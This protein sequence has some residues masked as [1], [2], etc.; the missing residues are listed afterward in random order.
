MHSASCIPI[1]HTKQKQE[2]VHDG[3]EGGGMVS[4]LQHGGI[5]SPGA[6]LTARKGYA[7]P[8]SLAHIYQVLVAK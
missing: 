8:A 6:M 7:D 5:K 1:L 2:H 4:L 3:V